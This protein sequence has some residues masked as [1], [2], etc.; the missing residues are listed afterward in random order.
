MRTVAKGM[1]LLSGGFDSPVAGH[2]LRERGARLDAVHFSLA[3]VTDDAAEG[4]ALRI[5]DLLGLAHLHVVPVAEAFME[6]VRTCAHRY[7]YV[8]SKRFMV[9]VAERLAQAEGCDVLVTGENLGQ[10]SSQTLPNL[11][12]IDAVATLP[13]VRPLIG[14]DKQEIIDRA[15]ALGTYGISAGPEVCDVLGPP[16][17]ATQARLDAV[18]REETRLDI[19]A[20]LE[21]A[22]AR[23]RCERLKG[24]A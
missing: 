19:G 9:R 1:L 5:A 17:P 18:L 21:D 11:R 24:A 3:P 20:L 22:L 4:K 10:V 6:I 8:L 23:A 14:F 13:V 16:K 2:L 7:Y 15:R 12:A